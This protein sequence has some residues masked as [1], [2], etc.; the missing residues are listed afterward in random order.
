MCAVARSHTRAVS[1]MDPSSTT[2]TSN[3]RRRSVWP[4]RLRRHCSSS[5]AR[6]RV[7]T[8]TLIDGRVIRP[9]MSEI[10]RGEDPQHAEAVL[11]RRCLLLLE[12]RRPTSVGVGPS[13]VRYR[14]SDG[15]VD[16]DGVHDPHGE[17]APGQSCRPDVLV[18]PAHRG[19]EVERE[20]EVE[21][22][23]VKADD[24]TDLHE[25]RL[26]GEA[27]ALLL[28]DGMIDERA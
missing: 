17:L 7:G 15:V 2:T 8:T 13:I 19:G 14:R 10:T 20:D 26:T 1:S 28:D 21:D 23:S 27:P 5:G 18:T 22:G 4:A 25:A 3:W 6:F 12:Q 16:G 11:Q 9:R 24:G